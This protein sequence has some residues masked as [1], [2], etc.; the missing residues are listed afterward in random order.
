METVEEVAPITPDT[1]SQILKVLPRTSTS[2][3]TTKRWYR[4]S[5][6]SN[7]QTKEIN[8]IFTKYLL[9]ATSTLPIYLECLRHT[10]L[11]YKE[12]GR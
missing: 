6:E 11:D 1:K 5:T 4:D 9:T 3:D 7:P 8:L 10:V 2:P 12:K